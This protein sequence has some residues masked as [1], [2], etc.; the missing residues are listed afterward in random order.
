MR[1]KGMTF[2]LSEINHF[3][4]VMASDSSET[5]TVQGKNTFTEVEKN[6]YFSRLNVGISTWGHATVG[7]Q[8]IDEWL[9]EA[10]D[11]FAQLGETDGILSGL[12]SHLAQ[13]LD[14]AYHFDGT[15][16]RS[17]IRMGLHIAG[18]HSS[19]N[20]A[21][22]FCHVFVEQD[23]PRFD[24]QETQLYLPEHI[25]AR[26]LRNGMLDEYGFGLFG[27]SRG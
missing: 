7:S 3:G 27:T 14:E 18:Y 1:R 9:Q 22:G 19:A 11:E 5:R 8:G 24:P 12:T 4:I 13:R 21:P 26:H 23:Y 6:H 2:L 16:R 10:V 17:T 20:D 25:P 15:R